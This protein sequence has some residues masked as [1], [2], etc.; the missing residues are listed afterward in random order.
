MGISRASGGH[1][2]QGL[3]G[4]VRLDPLDHRADGA[5]GK[6][7]GD[8]LMSVHG[9]AG[10]G[11]KEVARLHPARVAHHLAHR[12]AAPVQEFHLGER[13]EERIARVHL[14]PASQRITEPQRPS[15]ARR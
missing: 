3:P 7:L 14:L 5:R 10:D 15:S 4:I 9:H 11:H 13:A 6:G 2:G 12:C 8:E 1:P